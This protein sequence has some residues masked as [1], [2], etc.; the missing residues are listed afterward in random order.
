MKLIPTTLISAI[1]LCT[2]ALCSCSS[3]KDSG[4]TNDNVSAS[5]KAD[6]TTE[7]YAMGRDAA[8]RMVDDDLSRDQLDDRL[9]ETRAIISLLQRR[10]GNRQAADYE[11]GFTDGIKASGDTLATVL[12]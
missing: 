8:R 9:L 10:Y 11:A 7:A 6:T 5:V 1:V 2:T 12:F 3:D 4:S